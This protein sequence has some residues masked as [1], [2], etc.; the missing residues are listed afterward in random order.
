MFSN[1]RLSDIFTASSPAYLILSGPSGTGLT[2]N[3]TSQSET[4]FP[5]IAAVPVTTADTINYDRKSIGTSKE[6]TTSADIFN[7]Q[8]CTSTLSSTG[9]PACECGPAGG[10]FDSQN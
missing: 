8:S 3:L 5:E 4:Y 7:L 2:A 1:L 6:S 9:L 10:G